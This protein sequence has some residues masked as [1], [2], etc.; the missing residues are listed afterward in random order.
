MEERIQFEDEL[1]ELVPVSVR[2]I[3]IRT[4]LSTA[5][6][7]TLRHPADDLIFLFSERG[8]DEATWQSIDLRRSMFERPGSIIFWLNS[9]DLDLLTNYAPNIRSYIGLSVFQN[10]PNSIYMSDDEKMSRLQELRHRFGRSD[11]DTIRLAEEGNLEGTPSHTEWLIL[12]G[13][14]DLLRD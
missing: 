9:H 14:G 12:L 1:A 13:R 5:I 2:D 10:N 6:V 11:A 3:E 7:P 8:F 4:L